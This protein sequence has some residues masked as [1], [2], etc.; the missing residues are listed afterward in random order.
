MKQLVLLLGSLLL[1]V[2][3]LAQDRIYFKNGKITEAKIL[4]I[5]KNDISYKRADNPDGPTYR[6]LKEDI[7]KLVY[8]NGTVENFFEAKKETAVSPISP[9]P[10]KTP[11]AAEVP[12][13]ASSWSYKKNI[14]SYSVTDV[15]FK[16]ATLAYE[17][18]FSKGYLGVKIPVSFGLGSNKVFDVD[19]LN[20]YNNQETESQ[21]YYS[22]YIPPDNTKY[23]SIIRR[24]TVGLELNAYPFGQHQV[25]FF[26]GPAFYYGWLDYKYDETH[27]FAIQ[28]PYAGY[29]YDSYDYTITSKSAKANSY[30]GMINTGFAF[31]SSSDFTINLQ[32]GLGFRQTKSKFDTNTAT[33]FTPSFQIGYSF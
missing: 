16:R 4:E 17:H 31:K 12:K 3:G 13:Q 26:V 8:S 20:S 14:L 23:T 21:Y 32:I 29:Y 33:L 5:N 22:N 15:L 11:P 27:Y 24:N 1:A 2:C 6:D 18:I 10:A 30:S 7:D 28:I 19:Y 25:S 9:A